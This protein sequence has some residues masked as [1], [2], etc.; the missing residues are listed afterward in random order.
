MR[1]Y[2][3]LAILI[4]LALI[5]GCS[6]QA[7]EEQSV[8]DVQ[9]ESE[10]ALQQNQISG[11]V[12]AEADEV[13]EEQE[14]SPKD[15]TLLTDKEIKERIG[16][17]VLPESKFFDY[18]SSKC[19]RQWNTTDDETTVTLTVWIQTFSKTKSDLLKCYTFDSYEAID[20]MGGHYACWYHSGKAVNFGKDKYKFQISCTGEDCSQ[21]NM[22]ALA[23]MVV[24]KV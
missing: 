13:I 23:E 19:A 24:D 12:A 4:M 21:A 20:D 2:T 1:K 18:S 7:V 5:I 8:P 15:C 22:I 6:D 17:A 11:A 9:A 14:F 16:V 3:F 10:P